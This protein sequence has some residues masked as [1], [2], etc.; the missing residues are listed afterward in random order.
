MR[1][2]QQTLRQTGRPRVLTSRIV[3]PGL[4]IVR[5]MG[6]YVVGPSIDLPLELASGGLFFFPS[7]T[8]REQAGVI[9]MKNWPDVSATPSRSG[10]AQP[11]SRSVSGRF[12]FFFPCPV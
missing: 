2:T 3:L 5:A 12:A 9:P 6:G 10:V 8:C 7:K 1:A 11:P 4:S